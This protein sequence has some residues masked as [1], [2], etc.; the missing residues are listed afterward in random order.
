ML[1]CW[2]VVQLIEEIRLQKEIRIMMLFMIQIRNWMNIAVVEVRQMDVLLY[3]TTPY[4]YFGYDVTTEV[5]VS[6]VFAVCDEIAD[7]A[8]CGENAVYLE[9]GEKI[10]DSKDGGER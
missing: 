8:L 3:L 10:L 2:I 9:Y 7:V 4:I 5:T 1:V 6:S